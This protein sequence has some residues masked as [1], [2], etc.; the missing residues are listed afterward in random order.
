[1]N[2]V[3]GFLIHPRCRK[4]IKAFKAGYVFESI[5][6]VSGR[7]YVPKPV[8]N[9]YSHCMDALQAVAGLAQGVPD[10]D[11]YVGDYGGYGWL[12]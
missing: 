2:T 5:R 10:E 12:Y 7:Y 8:K 9:E 6:S 11:V 4:L 1:L 3:D